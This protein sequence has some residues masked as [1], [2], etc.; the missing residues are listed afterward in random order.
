MS[1]IFITRKYP[2]VKGGMETFSYQ[3]LRHFLPSHHSIIHAS[4][5]P[6][7]IFWIAPLLL[8]RALRKRSDASVFH[9]GD[10]VLAPLAI[11][12]KRF[13]TAPIVVTVHGLDITFAQQQWLY[14]W[15][16]KR[17]LRHIDLFV[18]ISKNTSQHLERFGV[19]KKDIRRIPHGVLPPKK[20]NKHSAKEYIANILNCSV[21]DLGDRCIILSV[22]RLVQR[23]GMPWFIEH[24]ML[25]I[26][27]QNPLLIIASDGP[28]RSRIESLITK[29]SLEE[30]ITV[31]GAVNDETLQQ[32][33]TG[34]DICVVPNIPVTD[35][36]EGFGFVAIE[37][38]AYGNVV[39]ASNI[40]GLPA[41]IHD[42]KNGVLLPPQDAKIW[43]DTLTYWISRNHERQ[44]FGRRAAE[45]TL[46]T[47]QWTQVAQQYQD[48]FDSLEKTDHKLCR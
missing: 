28:E 30:N 2:P 1:V 4:K 13:S 29:H 19:Q 36:I 48:V 25:K 45:Y 5:R 18:C 34:A 35:D 31:L 47:F 12:L 37:G 10:L 22:G 33:Y 20:M 15:L 23:K 11:V 21:E 8:L 38:A 17:S 46:Q 44:D 32:L 24:V 14:R 40:D 7:D 6:R 41:A 26:I 39:L 43:A 9:L 42:K 16:L 27:K 3:L